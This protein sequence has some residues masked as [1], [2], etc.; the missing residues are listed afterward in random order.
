VKNG[1]MSKKGGNSNFVRDRDDMVVVKH[2]C[3]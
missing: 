3:D 1:G 2:V